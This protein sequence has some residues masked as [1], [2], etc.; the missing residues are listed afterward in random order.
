MFE[1]T[2]PAPSMHT[3]VETSV[4]FSRGCNNND[5]SVPLSRYD[6]KGFFGAGSHNI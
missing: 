4:A 1:A 2:R 5:A 3:Y 6:I